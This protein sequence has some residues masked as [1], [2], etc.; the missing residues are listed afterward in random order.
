MANNLAVG[1]IETVGLT[2]LL[3]AV[4]AALKAA[5]VE[6]TGWDKVGS[7]LATAFFKGEVAAVKAAVEAGAEAGGQVGRVVCVNVIPRPHA[8][9][10]ILGD[11]I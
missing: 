6:M 3:E 1:M 2:A 11:W 9:L 8:D 4:D 10:G 5:D 7:G